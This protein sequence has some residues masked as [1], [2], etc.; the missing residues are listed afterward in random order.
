[1]IIIGPPLP[2]G[3]ARWSLKYKSLFPNAKHYI[4]GQEIPECEEAIVFSL[5]VDAFW[6][7]YEYLKSRIKK[8]HCMTICETETVHEDF[9]RLMKEFK[10]IG[11]PSEFCKRT[12]SKQFPE[13]EFYVVRAYVPPPS[14]KPYR[15]YTIGNMEDK[16]KNFGAMLRAFMRLENPNAYLV[17]KAQSNAPIKLDLPNVQIINQE[18]TEEEMTQIHDQCD[19]YVNTSHSEGIGMGPVEAALR[20][21]PVI[22]PDFGATSEYIKTPYL[23][24]CKRNK[25]GNGYYLFKK[26][27]TWGDPDEDMLYAFMKD[28][29]DKNLRHM[30]HTHT[31]EIMSPKNIIKEI[32]LFMDNDHSGSTTQ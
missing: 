4:L 19:C 25:I 28:A 23:V 16:R 20:D 27:M 29:L 3:I 11:V 26:D 22:I 14:P 18:L 15:F 7:C 6:D 31:K 17:V 13:N 5:P 21:K 30:D 10:R 2:G 12:F 8:I 1:M 32:D 24:K 9:G